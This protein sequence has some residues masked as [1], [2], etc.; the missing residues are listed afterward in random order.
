MKNVEICLSDFPMYQTKII[1][2]FYKMVIGSADLDELFYLLEI[3][4]SFMTGKN[5]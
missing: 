3:E 1:H 5:E 4:E 2:E